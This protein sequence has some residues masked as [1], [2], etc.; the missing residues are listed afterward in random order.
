M[1]DNSINQRI[2][3]ML[4]RKLDVETEALTKSTDLREFGLGVD[5][6]STMEIIVE[7]ESEFGIEIDESEFNPGVLR[8]VTFL[9]LYVSQKQ[10]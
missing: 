7:L 8:T 9:S 5:S 1:S 3:K 6:V 4:C 2:K 10:M